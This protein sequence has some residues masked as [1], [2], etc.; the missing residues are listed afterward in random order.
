MSNGGGFR[1][2]GATIPFS[3]V[4]QI[5]TIAAALVGAWYTMKL[6]IEG[7]REDF[8]EFVVAEHQ[9]TLDRIT[10]VETRQL[11]VRERLLALEKLNE[12]TFKRLDRI[13]ERIYGPDQSDE[14]WSSKGRVFQQEQYNRTHPDGGNK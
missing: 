2:L 13:E 12:A 1:V 10:T 11:D 5:L 4:V 6:Q 3:A 9:R 14:R 7:I 8:R